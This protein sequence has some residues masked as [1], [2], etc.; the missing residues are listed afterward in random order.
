M[1]RTWVSKKQFA[2]SMIV[3]LFLGAAFL[4]PS[5]VTLAENATAIPT[6]MSDTTIAVVPSKSE[7]NPDHQ[8]RCPD[9]G[10][11]VRFAVR[12]QPGRTDF[13]I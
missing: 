8:D 10:S 13:E 12:S 4:M 5:R 3:M 11:S 9:P 7:L 6:Q 2:V 1:K